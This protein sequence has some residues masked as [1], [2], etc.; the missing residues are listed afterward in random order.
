[1]LVSV[2]RVGPKWR[3]QNN[4]LQAFGYLSQE[5]ESEEEARAAEGD[6]VS[7]SQH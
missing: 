2:E 5:F 6:D 1:M 3:V 4:G 7:K